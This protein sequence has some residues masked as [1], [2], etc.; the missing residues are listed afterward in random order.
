MTK[1]ILVTGATG[2]I[3]KRLTE[4]LFEKPGLS[5]RLLTRSKNKIAN[6]VSSRAEVIEGDTFNK[7]LLIQA[8]KNIDVAYYLIH[9][10]GAGNDFEE[11]DRTSAKNFRDAC[12]ESK[13]KRVIYLGGLGVKETASK[14]LLSRIETGE[15]LSSAKEKLEVI[16]FRAGVIIG[17][18]SASFEIICSLIKKLPVMITPKWVSTK[19]QP[20]AADDVISYLVDAIELDINS[21]LIVDIGADQMSFKSMVEE[22]ARVMGLRRVLIPV[23][24][25]TPKLS[26]YWLILFSSAPLHMATALIEGLKSETV[27]LNDNSK[28]YFPHIKP[29]TFDKAVQHTIKN[30]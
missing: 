11:R 6:A 26:S 28:N 9:S 14:H 13:V 7:E 17:K 5:L 18:G 22:T 20:I 12:I 19:T 10:M 30:N 21:N 8:L 4:R 16:W 3:G 27:I 2:Y 24:V 15:I 1:R 23:P 29:M 25:L